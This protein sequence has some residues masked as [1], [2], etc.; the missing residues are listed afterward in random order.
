[1]AATLDALTQRWT[2]FLGKVE[3]RL[4]EVEAEAK[5]GLAE[6]IATEVLDPAPLANALT[7]VQAR[8]R[9][10]AK[11]V[12][13]AWDDTIAPECEAHD[14]GPG[15]RQVATLEAAGR[16]LVLRIEELGEALEAGARLQAAERLKALAEAELA[17]RKLTCA[18]C[19]APLPEPPVLHRV[20]NVT[21]THCRAVN[22]VRPGMAM[23]SYFAGGALDAKA[24]ASGRDSAKQLEQAERRFQARRHPSRED[25]E[26]LRQVM[27]AHWRAV[28]LVRGRETPGWTEARLPREVDVKVAQSLGPREAREGHRW[29]AVSFA[30]GRAAAGDV[31][32]LEA[33]LDGDGG[34][35]GFGVDE[36]LALTGER[37]DAKAFDMALLVAWQ[38]EGDGAPKAKWIAERRAEVV[39]FVRR[40]D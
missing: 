8:L 16:A 14:D 6:L 4:A 3:A 10:L 34:D 12:D 39:R 26:A 35:L 11:K 20:E 13:T 38:R 7:E 28:L 30:L 15:R 21:C 1:M 23:A 40:D 25:A 32:A 37:D 33:W 24:R 9:A 36:L 22:T 17:A 27:T 31:R 18:K 5:A 29:D 2:T 19:G